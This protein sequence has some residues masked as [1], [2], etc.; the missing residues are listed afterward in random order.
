MASAVNFTNPN[1]GEAYRN[2]V[3]GGKTDFFPSFA[4]HDGPSRQ[5]P[6]GCT[7]NVDGM[8][9]RTEWEGE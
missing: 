3:E 2:V 1:L 5:I 8:V 9:K 6:R 7:T 4:Q